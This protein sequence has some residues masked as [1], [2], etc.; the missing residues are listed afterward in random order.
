M[1]AP[2]PIGPLANRAE[3]VMVTVQKE[4]KAAKYRGTSVSTIV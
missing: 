1:N 3:Q 4:A 2:P